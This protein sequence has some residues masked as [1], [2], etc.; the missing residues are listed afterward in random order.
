[1][2][3]KHM[4]FKA[5]ERRLTELLDDGVEEKE[6]ERLATDDADGGLADYADNLRKRRQEDQI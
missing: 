3:W 4:W 6:A 5:Y 2:R 1:M